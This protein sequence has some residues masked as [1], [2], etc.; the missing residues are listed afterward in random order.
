MLPISN[1]AIYPFSTQAPREKNSVTLARYDGV[2]DTLKSNIGRILLLYTGTTATNLPNL[3]NH[4]RYKSDQSALLVNSSNLTPHP[5]PLEK[6][7]L[8][9]SFEYS[10]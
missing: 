5:L 8:V 7:F 9:V 1:C 6:W 4:A 3:E 10:N 2:N